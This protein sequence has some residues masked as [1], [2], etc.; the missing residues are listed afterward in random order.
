MLSLEKLKEERK[1]ST[2]SLPVDLTGSLAR[3][4][5]DVF[6]GQQSL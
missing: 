5:S 2:F 4:F 1:S 6:Y 3:G